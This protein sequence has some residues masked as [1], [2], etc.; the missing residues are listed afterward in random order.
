MTAVRD[1]V[2]DPDTVTTPR[3]DSSTI[4]RYLDRGQLQVVLRDRR[5]LQTEWEFPL[6]DGTREY[7][8]DAN[9][10]GDLDVLL[11]RVADS[12]LKPLTFVTWEQYQGAIGGRDEDSEGEP[13][14]YYYGNKLG[15]NTAAAKPP[16][17]SFHPTPGA[18]Q[19]GLKIRVRGFKHPDA[20]TQPP[21]ASKA[22]QLA[23]PYVEAAIA[24]AAMLCK[25]DE[26]DEA[27][28]AAQR[29]LFEG[30]MVRVKESLA[31]ETS[32]GPVQLPPW[33]SSGLATPRGP[34][35]RLW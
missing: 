15:T 10:Y 24:W 7:A 19:D 27:G 5:A 4:A 20:I 35:L 16:I 9:F 32:S 11:V 1:S 33:K 26:G 6:V 2:G 25:A 30:T 31:Y 14:Y 17:I 22:L 29:A 3:W 12:D 13:E 8:M 23:A 28:A 18:D 21:S 34:G